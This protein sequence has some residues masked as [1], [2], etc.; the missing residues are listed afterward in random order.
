MFAIVSI[1]KKQYIVSPGETISVPHL[2][3]NV[4]DVMKFFDVLL[5]NDGEKTAIG[6]PHLKNV[7]VEAKV[8]AQKKGEK[9]TVRRYKHKVRERRTIGF[10]PL[11]TDLSITAIS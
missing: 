4:G 11:L 6:T 10:R 8:I 5:T 7:T 2:E 1:A 9:L 3:G